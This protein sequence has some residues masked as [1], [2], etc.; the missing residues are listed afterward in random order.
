MKLRLLKFITIISISAFMLNACS[1]EG[2]VDDKKK[3]EEASKNENTE[4]SEDGSEE[5]KKDTSNAI[6]LAFEG[7]GTVEDT[8]PTKEEQQ[9]RILNVIRSGGNDIS[10]PFVSGSGDDSE[11]VSEDVFDK[12]EDSK[13]DDDKKPDEPK[14]PLFFDVGDSTVF[15]VGSYKEDYADRIIA[16]VN[17]KR[18]LF[19]FEPA[20]KNPSMCIV[21]DVRAKESA[22]YNGHTRANGTD[23]RTVA[24]DY[25]LDECIS[26]SL[27][28]CDPKLIVDAW[29]SNKTTRN[30]LLKEDYL[31]IG[32][33]YFNCGDYSLAVI[34]F[35]P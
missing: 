23:F 3:T 15:T 12:K 24:P 16:L 29:M 8:K 13:D 4:A 32:A 6:E 22:L 19:G 2:E 1:N 7:S 14:T 33:S 26:V 31:T 20:V 27:K 30:T 5:K 35:G 9:Q 25:F 17:E 34:A 18:K 10:K 11:P 28:D 21:A